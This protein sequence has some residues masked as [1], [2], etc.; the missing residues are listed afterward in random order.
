MVL[1]ATLCA[2][3]T[4]CI[5]QGASS[6]LYL[7]CGN[8]SCDLDSIVSALV[9][10]HYSAV[11]KLPSNSVSIPLLQCYREELALRPEVQLVFEMLGIKS[12]DLCCLDDISPSILSNVGKLTLVLVDHN[13]PTGK[14][15]S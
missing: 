15:S 11:M 6:E 7:T 8:E 4:T 2:V 14:Q 1:R 12:S 10:A 13:A 5:L 9:Y 3:N